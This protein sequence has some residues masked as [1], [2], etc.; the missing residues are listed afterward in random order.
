MT[1]NFL[2]MG[3]AKA[4]T[5][6]LYSLLKAH[7]RVCLSQPKETWFFDGASDEQGL[8]DYCASHFNHCPPG[9]V[10]GEVATSYLF[11]PH[12]AER[13]A[14]ELPRARLIAILRDPIQ[15]A[16]SDWWMMHTRGLDPLS[17]EEA[18]EDNLRRLAAGPDFSEP[19]DWTEHLAAIKSGKLHHRTYVD[20]GFYGSQLA[21]LRRLGVGQ[22][23][24][25]L[26]FEQMKRQGTP[27]LEQIFTFLGLASPPL[28]TLE[29]VFAQ[30][31]NEA[32]P[33]RRVGQ[34][35]G[36]LHQSG[37]TRLLPKSTKQALKQRLGKRRPA[38]RIA[39]AL[40]SRLEDIYRAQ[41]TELKLYRELDLNLWP[42]LCASS[43]LEAE[44]SGPD[45][46]I[47]P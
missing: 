45:P 15:R 33:S 31:Q 47:H 8:D 7:P 24:L 17:F 14:R 43:S 29:K 39:P 13:I 26:Q 36:I 19:K 21:R 2:V 5:T 20:Y 18:I 41:A 40:R 10:C 11:V 3:T 32:L 16:Y 12:A 9:M 44:R 25:V 42:S 34:L 27:Y 37:V 38:V 4:G 30:P 23:L 1:V 35:V 22:R 46:E 28:S 6:S